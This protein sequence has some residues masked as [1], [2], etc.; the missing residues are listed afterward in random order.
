M[1]G[2]QTIKSYAWEAP[3]VDRVESARSEE[4]L[5][6]RKFFF[7][8]GFWQGFMIY[9]EVLLALPL[10]INLVASNLTINPSTVMVGISM[11]NILSS[12]GVTATN[13]GFNGV[14]NYLSV[15]KRVEAVLLL[16]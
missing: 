11:L 5:R 16:E 2:I 10:L 7:L 9:S 8:T 14:V 12:C 4:I 1:L 6:F 15:F 3:L 13:L